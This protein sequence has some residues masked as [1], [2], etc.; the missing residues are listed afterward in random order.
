M[1]GDGAGVDRGRV[2]PDAVHQLVAREDPCRGCDARN[3]SRS[4]SRAVS[5]TASPALRHL[6]ART[7][8]HDVAERD[9]LGG[10]R[11]RR[12][13]PAEHRAHARRELARRERLRD[14]VVGAELEPDDPVGLLAACGEQDH[15]Q[16]RAAAD[17]AAEL[18]P[19]R[20]RQHHVEH[21]ELGSRSSI[22]A[23]RRRRRPPR[24]SV[25]PSRRE[26]A[27]PRRRARSA[28]RRRRERLS[29]SL[30]WLPLRVVCARPVLAD[31]AEGHSAQ[32]VAGRG[33]DERE[34]E[35]PDEQRERRRTSAR[36][37]ARPC[38]R[39]GSACRARRARAAARRRRRGR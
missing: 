33:V 30:L 26:V 35:V 3:Q 23:A 31:G 34:V 6:A 29:S 37:G 13:R 7:V 21:D 27:R 25:N 22:S 36:R 12:G 17:P 5:V 11:R 39:S 28:R 14:V 1:D 16:A 10:G 15:G 9:P 2:A 19:V 38:S 18:Q 4:N 32:R 20:A 24:A 8:E